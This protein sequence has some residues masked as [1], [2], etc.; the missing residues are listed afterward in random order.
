M[1]LKPHLFDYPDAPGSYAA[2]HAE[3]QALF[4][5]P[6]A[7]FL[8]VSRP[9]CPQCSNLLRLSATQRGI[10]IVVLDPKGFRYF[11]PNGEVKF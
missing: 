9:V 5:D 10:T 1:D 6:S 8:E 11:L 4:L 2:S 3:P 7:T